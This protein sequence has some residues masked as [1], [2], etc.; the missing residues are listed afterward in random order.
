MRENQEVMERARMHAAIS[1]Y[2]MTICKVVSIRDFQYSTLLPHPT[3]TFDCVKHS[4]VQRF[5]A[6]II[7]GRPYSCSTTIGQSVPE[8]GET[9]A[10]RVLQKHAASLLDGIAQ[11]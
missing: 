1:H 8:S 9:I 2:Q 10:E 4:V 7:S 6:G 3:L 11:H 5:A